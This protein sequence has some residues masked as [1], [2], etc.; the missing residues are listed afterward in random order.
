MSYIPIDSSAASSST[1]QR[2]TNDPAW[3]AAGM[4]SN[5][6]TPRPRAPH[7]A[8]ILDGVQH[9]VEGFLDKNS[10]QLP[11]Y[12]DKP[13]PS[14]L[15][16]RFRRWSSKRTLAIL[17]ALLLLLMYWNGA[18]TGSKNSVWS[19][20]GLGVPEERADWGKRRQEVVKA[21]E[22]SWDSYAAN[23]WGECCFDEYHPIAKTGKKMAPQGMGWIIIDAI[24]TMILMGLGSRVDQAREWLQNTLTWDQ[25]QDVNVFE[26]TIRMLGGLLSAH[27]LSTEFPDMAPTTNKDPTLYLNKARDLADRLLGAYD[28]ASGLPYASINLQT[29]KGIESHVDD[30]ASSTAEVATLQLEMKYLSFL[31]GNTTFWERAE[32]IMEILDNN[33]AE[34]GLVPIFVYATTGKFRG[35][36]IRLGSR[37]D[38]YYEYL[39]KQFLQT[40]VKEMVYKDMW[41]ETLAGIKKHLITYSQPT[42][43]TVLAEKP[44]GIKASLSPKMDHLV[45]FLPGTIALATTGGMPEWKARGMR[46][47]TKKQDEDM[48]LAREL[49]QTC[50]GMYK[51]M[52]TGLAAEITYFNVDVKKPPPYDPDHVMVPDSVFKDTSAEAS[53]RAD[54]DVHPTDKHNLQRPE[55]VESLFYMWRITGEPKYREWGWEMFRSF[56]NHTAVSNQGG[57]TSLGNADRV[58][59]QPR[60]NME[61]F[62]L[63]ET[64]KYFYLLFSPRTLLPLNDIVLNT[65]AHP[66][67]RFDMG[68]KFKT[69]WTRRPRDADGHVV[70][71]ESEVEEKKKLGGAAVQG[72]KLAVEADKTV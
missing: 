40:N 44:N 53:W 14:A 11:M 39:I 28:S 36:N 67:P 68:S 41:D 66:F 61:S 16:R 54:F 65:E 13:Y 59:P 35:D 69:G 32:R 58:P 34:D 50:W 46:W 62:W 8:S 70:G 37:G 56:V 33:G 19:F 71:A 31:T 45:C 26:T 49:T 22:L 51:V 21:F 30:G 1:H 72:G 4:N 5:N 43:F 18:F 24:D 25:D 12:K 47:W 38:S 9:K 64:L 27:Y 42:G 3:T 55:T 60:D 7:S 6:S 20:Y 52:A 23:G 63:A 48:Q 17:A 15:S 10:G 57:F 2:P 29:R